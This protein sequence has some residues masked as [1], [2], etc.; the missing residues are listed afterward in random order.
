QTGL[1]HIDK[2]LSERERAELINQWLPWRLDHIV[3]DLMRREGIDMW[4]IICRET[5]E[6]PLLW[7]LLP[8]PLLQGRRTNLLIFFDPGGDKP[9]ERY[10]LGGGGSLYKP[11]WEDRTRSQFENLADLIIKLDPKKIGINTSVDFR[12]A[13][14]LSAT[15]KEKLERHIGPEYSKRLVSAEKLCV[16]WLETRSPD[17]LNIYS[18]LCGIEHDLIAEFFSSGVI[19]PGVTT[20]DDVDWWIRDRITMLGLDT[21]FEPSVSIQRSP[22]MTELY[23][24]HPGI[25]RKGDLLHCDVGIRYLRLCT[26]MQWHAYVCL[27]DEQDAPEGLKN[28][29]AQAVRLA[30]VFMGEFREGLTGR[31]IADNTIQKATAEGLRPRLY[32]HPIGYYGHDAGTAIDN[33]PLNSVPEEMPRVMEYPLHLNTVYAIEFS[34]TTAVPE[35]NNK[36]VVISYEEQGVFTKDGC[37]WV[38]GNQTKLYLIR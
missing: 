7:S 9:V 3:P 21:W 8:E 28:A 19:T 29:L 10:S 4:L 17:E 18:H 36:D 15:M 14:G 20:T 37:R 5:N 13:D 23:K 31:Q 34:S 38:D 32:S 27:P 26:D 6:D 12:T 35:W 11:A 25:I 33:R 2:I 1:R 24:D 22:A 30:D 16:G